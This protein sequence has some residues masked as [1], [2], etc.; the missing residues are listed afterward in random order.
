MMSQLTS[1]PS[2]VPFHSL[3]SLPTAS[4]S[5]ASSRGTL[6][7]RSIN[8]S[9]RQRCKI[10]FFPFIVFCQFLCRFL[11]CLHLGCL[12]PHCLC[13]RCL[14]LHCQDNEHQNVTKKSVPK[15]SYQQTIV[16][17]SESVILGVHV[18]HQLGSGFLHLKDSM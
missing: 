16:I 17:V 12:N 15:D 1:A 7:C 4:F 13:L 14:R 3:T 2:L 10:P 6:R 8:F 18:F 5:A 9:T 11:S